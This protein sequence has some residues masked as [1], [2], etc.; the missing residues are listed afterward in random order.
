MPT[1]S[2]PMAGRSASSVVGPPPTRGRRALSPASWYCLTNWMAR[3]PTKRAN[4]ASASRLIWA[5]NGA[6]SLAF[7]GV[8]SFWTTCPPCSSKLR[9]KPPTTSQPKA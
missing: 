7:T 2:S 5:R 4:T 6:K 3:R 1:A 8:Q 9:W